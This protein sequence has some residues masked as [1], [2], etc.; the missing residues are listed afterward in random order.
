MN[1]M[2]IEDYLAHGG[3]LTS[4]GNAPPRYRGELMRLMASFVDSELAASAGFAEVINDA[5]GIKS[6]IAAARI[7]LEKADHA[8]RVLKIMAD[9]GADTARYEGVHPWAAR[10]DREA[11]IGAS[12]QGGDM[13]LSVFHYPL[14]G[15]VDAVVM[16]VLQGAAAVIQL[17]ELAKA[18]YQPLAEVFRAVTPREARH[19][20][21]GREGLG[22]IA[23]TQEGSAAARES[24][25]YWRPRVAAGFGTVGS[26]RFERLKRFG[27]RHRPNEAL[28]ADW[29]AQ[30]DAMLAD[31]NLN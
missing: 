15:W 24:V 2:S 28:L 19:A 20:E 12:R 25:A 9:F 29:N 18:S 17:Q 21:L 6:R 14:Q 11:D 5:P 23:A 27:L 7:V 22:K 13:R 31:L 8:E 4:P 1:D 30:I 16:N 26:A 3:K 10:L